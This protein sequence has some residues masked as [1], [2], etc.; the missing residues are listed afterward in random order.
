MKKRTSQMIIAN[1]YFW[2]LE[3]IDGCTRAKDS[4]LQGFKILKDFEASEI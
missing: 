2:R 3:T 1:N 4:Q